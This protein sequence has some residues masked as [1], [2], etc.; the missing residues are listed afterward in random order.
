M[1]IPPTNCIHQH[2]QRSE[3][4]VKLQDITAQV[5]EQL[6]TS[7]P[8]CS[9]GII[10]RRSFT[11]F[12]ESPT[13]VTYRAR[14]EGTL[15]KDGV[16]LIS[17]IEVWVR[18]GPHVV[19]TEV[20]MT[21]DSECL[22]AISDLSEEECSTPPPDP[23]IAT[24]ASTIEPSTNASSTETTIEP[25]TNASTTDTA[26]TD[27]MNP[28]SMTTT[29]T[30]DPTVSTDKQDSSDRTLAGIT[31]GVVAVVIVLSIAIVIII[32]VAMILKNRRGNLML[33][34]K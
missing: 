20:L 22:V 31:G 25:S 16:S 17:L 7:C 28:T 26:T 34:D 8:D 23:T 21:V 18:G 2:M 5:L 14:L 19:V 33:K 1:N 30:T 15:E 12:P 27:T 29:D 13:H 6:A 4:D 32:I 24:T 10:D 3:R 11:C 9:D